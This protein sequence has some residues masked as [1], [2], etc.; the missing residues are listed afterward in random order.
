MGSLG[1]AIGSKI[2]S[3]SITEFGWKYGYMMMISLTIL[4][5]LIPLGKLLVD[6]VKDIYQLKKKQ[7]M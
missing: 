4:V 5:T 7:R 2:I 6:D 3:I 1:A